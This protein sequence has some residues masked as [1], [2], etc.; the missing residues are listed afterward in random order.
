MVSDLKCDHFHKPAITNHLIDQT[1]GEYNQEL[2]R[3]LLPYRLA[4]LRNVHERVA[5]LDDDDQ[6][7]LDEVK[8][9][10]SVDANLGL[11]KAGYGQERQR[12][13]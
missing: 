1:D 3:L 6:R 10:W 4:T 13:K 9:K 2:W 7:E 5:L 11:V 8:H 12:Q